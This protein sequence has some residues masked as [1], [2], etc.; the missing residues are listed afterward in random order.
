MLK[1]AAVGDKTVLAP[2]IVTLNEAAV[3][4]RTDWRTPVGVCRTYRAV[5]D[6]D[7][8]AVDIAA[9]KSLRSGL[10]RIIVS[11]WTVVAPEVWKCSVSIR[12]PEPSVGACIQPFVMRSS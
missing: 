5:A 12:L 1:L 2:G 3:G 11:R 6:A 4:D 9:R 7:G 10:P 8:S